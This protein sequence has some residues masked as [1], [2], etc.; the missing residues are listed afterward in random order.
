M[1]SA[2]QSLRYK[3]ESHLHRADQ[4]LQ[5]LA[6]GHEGEHVEGQVQDAHVED[7]RRRHPPHCR[8]AEVNVCKAEIS[9]NELARLFDHAEC[10]IQGNMHGAPGKEQ[11]A[12]GGFP[13]Q[14]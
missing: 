5:G 8:R 4:A 12:M 10:A 2:G 11:L 7:R 1:T 13:K 14:V 6:D 9:R 3:R